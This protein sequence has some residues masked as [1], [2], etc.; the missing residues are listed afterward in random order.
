MRLLPT[1]GIAHER[2]KLPQVKMEEIICEVWAEAKKCVRVGVS[3]KIASMRITLVGQC[4]YF[5]RQE[6]MLG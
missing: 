5:V 6:L 3:E 4:N 1:G 2:R